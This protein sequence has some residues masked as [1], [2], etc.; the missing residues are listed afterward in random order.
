[1]KTAELKISIQVRLPS[2]RR[3]IRVMA[4]KKFFSNQSKG[5]YPF[6]L[7]HF[8]EILKQLLSITASW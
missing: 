2:P 7:I 6:S 8:T 1:M 4:T 5:L 3:Q